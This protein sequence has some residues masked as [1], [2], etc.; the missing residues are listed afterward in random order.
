M[1]NVSFWYDDDDNYDYDDYGDVNPVT[2]NMQHCGAKTQK[3]YRSL[4]R[5]LV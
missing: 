2:E 1:E 4:A 3:L 5:R